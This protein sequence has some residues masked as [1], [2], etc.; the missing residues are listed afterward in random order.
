MLDVGVDPDAVRNSEGLRGS[1]G[2]V[3]V[4]GTLSRT[5]LHTSRRIVRAIINKQY[6]AAL[7]VNELGLSGA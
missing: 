4:I 3:R 5:S 6:V 1:D 2:F 7:V